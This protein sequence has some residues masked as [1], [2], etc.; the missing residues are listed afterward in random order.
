MNHHDLVTRY[1]DAVNSEDWTALEGVFHPNA[2]FQ[3]PGAAPR[4]GRE[5][6][7][8]LFPRLFR[9]WDTHLDAPLRSIHQGDA[10]AVEIQFSGVSTSGRTITFEAVDLFTFADGQVIGLRSFYDLLAVRRELTAGEAGCQ[11]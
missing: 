4:K 5:E 9:A 2:T 6:I 1:F 3:T 11:T 8:S 7:L 10:A